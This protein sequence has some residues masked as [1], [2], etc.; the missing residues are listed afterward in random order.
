MHEEAREL[1]DE[2]VLG[3]QRWFDLFN[4]KNGAEGMACEAEGRIVR[5]GVEA[6]RIQAI[7]E[8]RAFREWL[9]EDLEAKC[10]SCGWTGHPSELVQTDEY[11]DMNPESEPLKGCPS[12]GSSNITSV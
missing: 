4:A 12:C 2:L 6:M 7:A 9:S 11:P 3:E 10:L 1:F 5:A 8:R